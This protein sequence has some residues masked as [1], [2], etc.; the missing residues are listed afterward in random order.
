MRLL[1]HT[2]S[3]RTA[4]GA[5]GVFPGPSRAIG[6]ELSAVSPAK[7]PFPIQLHTAVLDFLQPAAST[8]LSPRDGH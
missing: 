7:G 1:T 5:K 4:T 6:W 2:Y 8:E 3:S